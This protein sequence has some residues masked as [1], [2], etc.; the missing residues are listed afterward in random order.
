MT[1]YKLDIPQHFMLVA[2]AA[3]FGLFLIYP[4]GFMLR[5]AFW[6]EGSLPFDNFVLLFAN[7]LVVEALTNSFIIATLTTFL[8]TCIAMPLAHALTHYRFRGRTLLSTLL[9]APMILPPFVGAV[10]VRQLLAR[11]GTLNLLLMDLGILPPNEPIDWLGTNGFCGVVIL[12]VIG[13]Y[14]VMLL[15]LMAAMSNIDLCLVEAAQNLGATKWRVFRTVTLP[16]IAPGWF[17]G[18]AVVF[19]W[20]FTD[21]GTP[22][23]FGYSRVVAVQIFDS[24]SQL[25]TNPIGYALVVVVLMCTL[26]LFVIGRQVLAKYSA[27]TATIMRTGVVGTEATTCQTIVI[28]LSA[29]LVLVIA[30]L[31]H[32]GVIVQSF[33]GKWFLSVLPTE[34]TLDGYR[35]IL[36]RG[37]ASLSVRNSIVF[38]TLSAVVD[39]VIGMAIAW[40]ITRRKTPFNGVL[41]ALAMLPLGLP[42]L[43]LAF[44]Y[45]AGFDVAVSCLNPRENPAPLLVISYSVRRLPYL[46]RSAVAGFQQANVI[47]EEASANLG[48]STWRTLRRITMPMVSAHLVAGGI[49]VFAFAVLEVS[50][51]LILAMREQFFPITK[52]IYQLLGRIEPNA[53]TVASALGVVGMIVLGISLAAATRIMGSRVGSLFR[54]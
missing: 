40:L 53:P 29:C 45:L 8:T 54:L 13:L 48:A 44:G 9:L 52:M 19:I 27:Y 24:I 51:S 46:V 22:L 42:G 10:G 38:A 16:L 1:R 23:V 31:P 17:A 49:L 11:F 35:E 30:L 14:P 41:D 25:N 3:F 50:D 21:L 20:A 43:V 39:V 6:S 18:A 26:G 32:L 15:N 34:W 28:W 2:L 5:Q 7:P 36:T 12:Q 4:V 33:S 47:Y 37:L